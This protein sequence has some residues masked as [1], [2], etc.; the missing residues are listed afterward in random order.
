[1]DHLIFNTSQ[2]I[3]K[4]PH[5]PEIYVQQLGELNRQI[6]D[7]ISALS[8]DAIGAF[9]QSLGRQEV[10]CDALKRLLKE[11]PALQSDSEWLLPIRTA[12]QDLRRVNQT[13]AE[14]VHQLAQHIEIMGSLHAS[15]TAGSCHDDPTRGG[16]IC[17]FEA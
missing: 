3:P 12:A 14:L 13:Y 10:M 1:M 8:A 5:F 4:Q 7:A 9:E 11:L 16:R 15:Y 17:S 2:E 6:A